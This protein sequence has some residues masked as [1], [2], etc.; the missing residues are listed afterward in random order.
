MTAL[1]LLRQDTGQLLRL[2]APIL[3]TQVAQ[4]GYGL[5]DTVMAGQVSA[6]DLAAVA[7]GAGLWLPV[8]LLCLG[9]LSATTPLVAGQLGAGQSQMVV[10]RVQQGLWVARGVGVL[11]TALLQAVPWL[12]DWAGVPASLQPKA[13]LFLQGISLGMPASCV[14]AVLR[15][16]SEA[17]H[18]PVPVTV[19]S[20][21]GLLLTIPLNWVL[22][23]GLFGLPALGGPGCGFASATVMWLLAVV[24]WV[25]VHRAR[26]YAA[27][28]L[29]WGLHRPD[30]AQIWAFLRLG[31]P[32]GVATFFEAS[33]F[34]VAAVVLSPLGETTVAAH[35]IAL[36]V[37][38]QLFM[39]PLSLSMALSILVGHRHGAGDL[40]AVRRVV[41]LG[42]GLSTVLS[43]LS[44]TALLSL[45]PWIPKAY[46]Q[47]VAVQALA[48]TL[49]LFAAAYQL[50]DGWQVCSAGILRG[51]HD[52]RATM[53][54]TLLCYWG[55]A[56]PLGYVLGRHTDWGAAGLWSGLV[57]GL[58]GA[59]VLLLWRVHQQLYKILPALTK[60]HDNPARG[61]P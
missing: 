44:I 42:L 50:V 25:Y 34:C 48:G 5:I 30:A 2:M 12:F 23:H 8:L 46:T 49:L 59:A 35:Q 17:L 1:P 4:A 27:V 24:L 37:T 53:W 40:A 14:Y 9:V 21:F 55:V 38:S 60:R 29:P 51:L 56:F 13:Q 28:R 52:T 16:Y 3:L 20:L 33:L 32:I 43:L 54:I 26:R 7:I 36:S 58:L 22:I 39:I 61:M 18:Q 11:G 6:T 31:L 10:P 19:I 45:H 41:K 15:G 57:V 47:D